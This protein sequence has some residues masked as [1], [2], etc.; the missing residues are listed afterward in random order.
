MKKIN[1]LGLF[2]LVLLICCK[3]DEENLIGPGSESA[4]PPRKSNLVVELPETFEGKILLDG[5]NDEAFTKRDWQGIPS[6]VVSQQGVIFVAWYTGSKGEGPGNYITVS[7]S[8]DKG[9]TWNHNAL[10]VIPAK[11]EIRFFD[12]ALW[13]DKYGNVF[14]SWSKS[15]NSLW[16]GKGGVWFTKIGFEN[17][18]TFTMPRRLADGVMMNRPS[19]D[20]SKTSLLYPIA[21]W[22][23]GGTVNS[24][25]FVYK[26]TYNDQY[27]NSRG[28][29][30]VSSIK[31]D[32]NLRL[33]DEHQVIQLKDKSYL[34]MIR[35]IDGIYFTK[36]KDLRNWDKVKKFTAVGKTASSR[37]FL[38]RL[39]SGKLALVLSNSVERSNMKIFLSDDEA[40]SW[41]YSMLIDVKLGVSYPD[42]AQSPDGTINIVYDFNRFNEMHIN[43]VSFKEEDVMKN[44]Y[45]NIFRTLVSGKQ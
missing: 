39:K 43:L 30:K 19:E 38:G 20:I 11:P 33:Y 31:F 35:G 28:F 1:L 27:N 14:L 6:V 37:F 44:N 13:T 10:I 2:L 3:K 34:V 41:K 42:L 17:R 36:S 7:V 9:V 29:T 8:T 15:R 25:I 40:K 12:P 21:V 26:S 24:G 16:D 32:D 18:F 23:M 22:K 4:I 5:N 45:Q